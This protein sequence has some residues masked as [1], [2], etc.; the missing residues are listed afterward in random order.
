M[1]SKTLCRRPSPTR[2]RRPPT[3]H[4]LITTPSSRTDGVKVPPTRASDRVTS[5]FGPSKPRDRST[6]AGDYPTKTIVV[7]L[8]QGR[9]TETKLAFYFTSMTNQFKSN[10]VIVYD[11]HI[12]IWR[13]K[14]EKNEQYSYRIKRRP[15]IKINLQAV[16]ARGRLGTQPRSRQTAAR[17]AGDRYVILHPACNWIWRSGNICN[18]IRRMTA[19]RK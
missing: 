4:R 3:N 16:I 17:K 13:I 14:Q 10:I 12:H 19:N 9:Q 18:F 15:R 5:D 11:K 7:S 2:R 8:L 1:R 6:T